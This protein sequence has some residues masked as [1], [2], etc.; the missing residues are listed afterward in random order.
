[1]SKKYFID[2]NR[3]QQILINLL[4]NAIKF[5]RNGDEINI[6]IN[7]SSTMEPHTT[8]ITI[9]V[10]DSGI[11]MSPDDVSGLFQPF[12]RTKD[13]KSRERNPNGH[14]LGLSISSQIAEGLGGSLKCESEL[15]VGTSFIFSFTAKKIIDHAPIKPKVIEGGKKPKAKPKKK[16]VAKLPSI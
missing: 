11:G 9:Q 7:E 3:V 1:M 4:S 8:K 15:G 16:T 14:G 5:S 13:S 2:A 10:M 12:Y 6:Q